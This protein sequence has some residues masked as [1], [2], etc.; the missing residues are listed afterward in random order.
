M[1]LY[2]REGRQTL[3]GYSKAEENSCFC[4]DCGWGFGQ[5]WTREG[6]SLFEGVWSAAVCGQDYGD[7]GFGEL[8]GY[9]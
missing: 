1:R 8:G 4:E 7:F 9:L 3:T 6:I 2:L 5:R